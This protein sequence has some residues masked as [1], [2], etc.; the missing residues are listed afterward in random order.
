[1]L[2]TSNRLRSMLIL[3]C[4]AKRW[5]LA[6]FT[7]CAS[8]KS[9]DVPINQKVIKVAKN[10]KI[11]FFMITSLV[12]DIRKKLIVKKQVQITI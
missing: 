1:M 3:V 2:I 5:E 4:Q 11:L 7:V 6:K 9:L 12:D 10:A 8:D